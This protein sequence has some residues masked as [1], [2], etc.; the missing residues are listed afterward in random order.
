MKKTILA[1]A[2]LALLLVF[3]SCGS[4]LIKIT[5]DGDKYIDKTNDITYYGAT[6]SYEPRAVGAQYAHYGDT[7]LCQIKGLEPAE[8]LTESYDGIG[9][10]YYSS[11]ITLPTLN[12]FEPTEIYICIEEAIT[13]QIGKVAVQSDVDA[14]AAAMTGGEAVD[15]P[16]AGDD[17]FHLKFLSDT[18]Y[19]IYYDILYIED[20]ASDENYLYDRG[21]KKCVAVGDLMKKYLPDDVETTAETD[22]AIDTDAD[23]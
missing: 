17:S 7:V 21:T 19:G 5:V 23:A 10:V 8:W 18:Y 20:S 2:A 15:M 13:M 14:I 4:N 1:G 16:L 12:N 11:A 9:S 3:T 22:T 6:V